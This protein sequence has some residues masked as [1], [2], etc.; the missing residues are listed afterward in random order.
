MVV[1]LEMSGVLPFGVIRD[2]LLVDVN[3][4]FV[5]F[6]GWKRDELLGA[7]FL[8]RV[9][10]YDRARVRERH[11]RRLRGELVPES[12]ELDVVHADG[13]SRHVEVWIKVGAGTDV[14]FELADRTHLA[15]R[16][17]HLRELAGLGAAVQREHAEERI[18]SVLGEGLVGLGI[19]W[20]RILCDDD[21]LEVIDVGA[22]NGSM[23]R[24]EREARIQVRGARGPWDVA[25]RRAW[26]EGSAFLDDLPLNADMF[27]GGAAAGQ[28]ARTVAR[29]AALGRAIALRIDVQQRPWQLLMVMADWLLEEDLASFG[30]LRIQVS[31]A[32][33]AARVIANLSARNDELAALNVIAG[34]AGAGSELR[35]LFQVTASSLMRLLGT[36]WLSIYLIEEGAAEATLAFNMGL[37]ESIVESASRIPLVG[38]IFGVVNRTAKPVVWRWSE[39]PDDLQE[40]L[41][42]MQF[43][44]ATSVPLIAGARVVGAMN[45][46]YADEAALLPSHVEVLQ[47]AGA[48]FAAAVRAKRLLDDLRQSYADLA[49]A[50]E[51]L[52]QRER[53]AALGELAAIVAHEI[54]NPLGAVFNAIGAIRQ[55]A[56]AGGDTRLTTLLAILEEEASRMN[57]I[58]GDLLDFARP[59]SAALRPERIEPIVTEAIDAATADATGPIHVDRQVD[60]DLPPVPVDVRL[61]RQAILNV[62]INAVQALGPRGGTITL[63]M[64][65]DRGAVRI[66]IE[67]TGPGIATEHQPRV[68]EPFFTTRPSGTGL[69]L[70]VVKR[71]VDVHHGETSLRTAGGA[72]TTFV[73]R[74]PVAPLS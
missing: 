39:M 22:P 30:L 23:E 15:R 53:L 35:A 60:S 43:A 8:D 21:G 1:V 44:V 17:A 36:K 19:A 65:H 56:S 42:P 61:L 24:L 69:G 73:I 4:A 6:L 5:G 57:E 68:F 63:R 7:S 38:P 54:R 50:Q 10:E 71:I 48:H 12:Y 31:A 47:A 32:L 66:E 33:D 74:L 26:E 49:R 41:A 46:G 25:A 20:G 2:G 16:R 27:F 13:S 18:F 34:A 70:T 11:E 40:R 67:D 72:G 37:P 28:I 14:M 51:Q 45:T 29:E 9:A 3:D 59:V 62:A 55:Q 52:V 58:V 64:H